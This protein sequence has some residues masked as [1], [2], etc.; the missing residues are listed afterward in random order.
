MGLKLLANS[1]SFLNSCWK[2]GFLLT[3][4]KS[5]WAMVLQ[6]IK[7]GQFVFANYRVLRYV[8]SVKCCKNLPISLSKLWRFHCSRTVMVKC[9]I[10]L[11]KSLKLKNY[12]C[13]ISLP[14]ERSYTLTNL[15]NL[16][17]LFLCKPSEKPRA[18]QEFHGVPVAACCNS[19][20]D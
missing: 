1:N 14:L 18:S 6:Q 15:L 9:F 13:Q 2:A 8:I 5:V 7:S 17:G 3:R 10:S 20:F 11:G 16:R 19:A 12:K 4:Q